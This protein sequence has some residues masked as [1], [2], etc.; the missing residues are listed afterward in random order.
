MFMF[1][2]WYV[3][4]EAT[5]RTPFTYLG[6][7]GKRQIEQESETERWVLQKRTEKNV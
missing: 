5:K 2:A 6:Y 1:E 3:P 7:L 4:T